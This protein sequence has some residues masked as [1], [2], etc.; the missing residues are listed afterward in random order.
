MDRHETGRLPAN[1]FPGRPGPTD[2]SR[3]KH[4]EGGEIATH[5]ERLA[6]AS[7]LWPSSLTALPE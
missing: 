3:E 4:G 7:L 2:E 5:S 1:L 6:H